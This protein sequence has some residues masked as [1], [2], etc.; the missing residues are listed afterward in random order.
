VGFA[1]LSRMMLTIG[2]ICEEESESW[3][4]CG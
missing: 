2:N 1:I 3:E 4:G